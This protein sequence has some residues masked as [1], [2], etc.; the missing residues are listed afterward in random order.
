MSVWG[1]L[2]LWLAKNNKEHDAIKSIHV[3]VEVLKRD[4]STASVKEIARKQKQLVH[5]SESQY[6]QHKI[7]YLQKRF[8][9][10]LKILTVLK[11]TSEK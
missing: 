2:N 8:A 4:Y 11:S 3:E 10:T 1:F 9:R 6:E 5:T 7:E